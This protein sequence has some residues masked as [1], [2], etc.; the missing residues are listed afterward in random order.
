LEKEISFLTG[1]GCNIRVAES[2][3]AFVVRK[4]FHP[5]LGARPMRDAAEK[6]VGDAV[7]VA[8]L[9]NGCADGCLTADPANDRLKIE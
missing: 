6:L 2:V 3:L 5:K 9:L 7:A 4:G 8:L 1:R